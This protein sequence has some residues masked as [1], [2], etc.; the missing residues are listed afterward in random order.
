MLDITT[1]CTLDRIKD[2]YR[3]IELALENTPGARIHVALVQM[4]TDDP[5]AWYSAE[6][7]LASRS[8]V[9]TKMV[10]FNELDNWGRLVYFDVLKSKLTNIFDLNRMLYI[11]VDVDVIDDLTPVWSDI[12]EWPS[13]CMRVG[14]TYDPW[15]S[16][17]EIAIFDKLTKGSSAHW[18][19]LY[20][21]GFMCVKDPD[22]TLSKEVGAIFDDLMG[23]EYLEQSIMPGTLLWNLWMY[24]YPDSISRTKA[25]EHVWHTTFFGGDRIFD[26][27]SLHFNGPFKHIRHHCT[28]QKDHWKGNTIT[29]SPAVGEYIW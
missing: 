29:L 11:D 9:V 3:F 23:F 6:A 7:K 21:T 27:R 22:R 2:L 17:S 13:P 25:I 20:Q 5:K 18:V 12:P 26:A 28:Y 15:H 4:P 16:D 1:M 14:A 24:G 19:D 8:E 10:K